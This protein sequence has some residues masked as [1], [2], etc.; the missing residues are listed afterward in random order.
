MK[1]HCCSRD[2]IRW[3]LESRYENMK[4]GEEIF[5]SIKKFHIKGTKL[6]VFDLIITSSVKEVKDEKKI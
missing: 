3:E 6:K 5:V 2:K 1:Y 4:D